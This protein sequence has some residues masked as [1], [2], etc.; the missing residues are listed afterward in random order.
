MSTKTPEAIA[1]ALFDSLESGDF[2]TWEAQLAP[3]FTCSYPGL[4]GSHGKAAALAYNTPFP[5]GFPDLEFK[6]LASARSGDLVYL[7]WSGTGTHKGPLCTPAGTLPPTGRSVTL[8]GVIVVTVTGG[9]IQR[10][11]AYWNVAELIEPLT[12]QMAA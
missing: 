5:V 1:R 6:I 2:S 4:R 10:E 3:G 9:L 11:E 8:T 7:T 12:A